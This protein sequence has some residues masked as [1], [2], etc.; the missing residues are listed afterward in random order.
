MSYSCIWG[1][2]LKQNLPIIGRVNEPRMN[3]LHKY[4]YERGKNISGGFHSQINF[5]ELKS[6]ENKK[7]DLWLKSK[8][9]NG[10]VKGTDRENNYPN[11]KN[12]DLYFTLN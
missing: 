3:F 12:H 11:F 4:G 5:E 10:W 7:G 6:L 8:R 9:S 2:G 1:L